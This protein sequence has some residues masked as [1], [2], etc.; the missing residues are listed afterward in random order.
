M[1]SYPERLLVGAS[2]LVFCI[3]TTLS[4]NEEDASSTSRSQ[5]DKLLDT[6]SASSSLVN[7]GDDIHESGP[8][9][10]RVEEEQS[11]NEDEAL[12]NSTASA[13]GGSESGIF[14]RNFR[15]LRNSSGSLPEGAPA[16]PRADQYEDRRVS[17]TGTRSPIMRTLNR[18]GSRRNTSSS[19]I[20]GDG[21]GSEAGGNNSSQSL[22]I[23][24]S[25]AFSEALQQGQ[26]FFQRARFIPISARH[27]FPPSKDPTG[28]SNRVVALT[29]LLPG[30]YE[31]PPRPSQHQ[32]HQQTKRSRVHSATQ[33]RPIDGILPSGWLEKHAAALPSVIVVVAQIHPPHQQ[34]QQR[35]DDL[36]VETLENLQHSLALKRKLDIKV[37]A[38]VQEGVSPILADQWSQGILGR[39]PSFIQDDNN[40]NPSTVEPENL[41]T[42]VYARELRSVDQSDAPAGVD[43]SN[44]NDGSTEGSSFALPKLNHSIRKSSLRYYK[45]RSRAVKDKLLRLGGPQAAIN[46]SPALFPLMVR[47]CFKA[48]VFYEF[49]WKQEK[50][51]KYM[52]EA[53]RLVEAY[54]RYL[55]MRAQHEDDDNQYVDELDKK[56][57]VD[58]DL[59]L[60][61]MP[62]LSEISTTPSA[63]SREEVFDCGEGVEM[64]LPST[65]TVASTTTTT[66][67]GDDYYSMGPLPDI[68]EDMVDQCRAVADWLNFKIL[69]MCLVSHD[70][71]GIIAASLQW[72]RHVRAFCCPRRSF[73]H[74]PIAPWLDWSYMSQQLIVVSQLLERYPPRSLGKLGAAGAENHDED[75]LR[76]CPWRTFEAASEALLKTGH[77]IR[78]VMKQGGLSS[79]PLGKEPENGAVRIR[80]V[81]GIDHEGFRPK[82]EEESKKNHMELALDHAFRGIAL[83]GKEAEQL[84]KSNVLTPWTRSGARL[85]YLAGGA[86]LGLNRYS[87]A[88]PHLEKAVG[89]CKGWN[90]LES[91]VQR[92]L[93]ECYEKQ[94]VESTASTDGEGDSRVTR[95]SSLLD[96]YFGAKL[97]AKELNCSIEK[98]AKR[99]DLDTFESDGDKYLRWN[100]SCI[101]DEIG[102][103]AVQPFSFA[104]TFPGCTHATLG[105]KV[106][107]HVWIKSNLGYSVCVNRLSLLTFLGSFTTSSEEFPSASK[108]SSGDK[109]TM[110]VKPNEEIEFVTDIMLPMD[111]NPVP[112]NGTGSAVVESSA[113]APKT[114][115]AKKTDELVYESRA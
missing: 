45:D 68:A 109:A 25:P 32:Q 6:I 13:V 40:N 98:L 85:H 103:T 73:L 108:H 92:L 55:L 71:S 99:N 19:S 34:S 78:L 16:S 9:M 100:W 48:A 89:L 23:D 115:M 5:F 22:G 27:G 88:I 102:G 81:G 64:S 113:S 77:R 80:Y 43:T 24:V 20:G 52:V 106:K 4:G 42:L 91:L 87:E 15:R 28:G 30:Q 94:G 66:S 75:L 61:P 101:D 90:Y 62:S 17:F 83:Y 26:S 74:R 1:E 114:T 72:Q 63:P 56:R 33:K 51:L 29:G 53:Y 36:L 67:S 12:L 47:Y 7:D 3:D 44:L 50:T 93:V 82:F 97:S 31:Q 39:L 111:L 76:C 35:Q 59:E 110:I 60:P 79:I 21:T 107:A 14:A 105:E 46:L 37:V 86:L 69:Q 57:T 96:C 70:K 104:L 49:Q 112:T 11:D 8:M 10:Q 38:L 54:F 41:V 58:K 84:K 95:T 65:T 18:M 2:P